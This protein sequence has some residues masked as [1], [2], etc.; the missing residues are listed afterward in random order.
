[1]AWPPAVWGLA[2]LTA[3]LASALAA[4]AVWGVSLIGLIYI[5]LPITVGHAVLL[6]LPTAL[7]FRHRGWTHVLAAIAGGFLVGAIP[8]GVLT[9]GSIV[10]GGMASPSKL[11]K[12][13]EVVGTVGGL[14]APGGLAFW[15]TLRAAGQFR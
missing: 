6:G 5:T 15:L 14:G 7:Y 9:V 4:G 11:M 1:M 8:I 13:L 2:L 3:A 10:V 12:G